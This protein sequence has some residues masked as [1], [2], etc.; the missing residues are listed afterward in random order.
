MADP[1]DVQP[2]RVPGNQ[3]LP[4]LDELIKWALR[5]AAPYLGE[6]F[7]SWDKGKLVEI[8]SKFIPKTLPGEMGCMKA[9]Y[10]VLGIL[11]SPDT[12]RKLQ[13]EVYTNARKQAEA[14]AKLHPDELK[15]KIDEAK[16]GNDKLTDAEARWNAID[17]LTSPFNSSDHL[18]QLMGEKDL[19]G[20][21]VHSP[22]TGAEQ[23][24]RDMTGDGSGVYFYGLAVNDNHTV[25]LAVERAADGT[26]KMY[27]LDQNNPGLSHEVKAG[28]L[29]TELGNVPGGTTTTNIYAL[30]PPR[31]GA[32]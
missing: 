20:A 5:K 14:W 31:G 8:K 26:Q 2:T 28:Q 19:A 9:C 13:Q 3:P 18:F 25:T 11:Y 22:N 24:I 15:K 30:R 16:A 12:S 1:W 7:Y 17:Q 4:K 27:W 6:A 21:K 10:N 23:A 32:S 29:G